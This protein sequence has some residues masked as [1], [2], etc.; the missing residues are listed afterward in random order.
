MIERAILMI[1]LMSS[2]FPKHEATIH[3][4][5]SESHIIRILMEIKGKYYISKI[6]EFQCDSLQ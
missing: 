4:H 6:C 1:I 3:L 5:A 2:F